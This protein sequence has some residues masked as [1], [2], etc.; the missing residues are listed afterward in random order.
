[1]LPVPLVP[2]IF[3][4]VGVYP[5]VDIYAI[6]TV[7]PM[8]MPSLGVCRLLKECLMNMLSNDKK[9]R[10]AMRK[11]NR[12]PKPFYKIKKIVLFERNKFLK[13]FAK[14]S[15]G[16][17][18]QVDF[19]KADRTHNLSGAF[20]AKY[21]IDMLEA[22]DFERPV[23]LSPFLGAIV[24]VFCG[25]ENNAPVTKVLTLYSDFN[26]TLKRKLTQPCLTGKE[27]SNPSKMIRDYQTI[28]KIQSL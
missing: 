16:F 6:F 8:H 27:L 13:L 10:N 28:W 9:T 1:M 4:I 11:S 20:G 22:S 14:Q 12:K 19:S 17:N 5:S 18:L 15:P 21:L 25:N 26:I 7:E 2:H 3:A 23:Q 24:D